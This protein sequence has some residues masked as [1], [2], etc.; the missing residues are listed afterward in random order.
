MLNRIVDVGL[1]SGWS[2]FEETPIRIPKVKVRPQPTHD[3]SSDVASNSG[4]F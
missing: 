3:V 2:E 4:T 1:R